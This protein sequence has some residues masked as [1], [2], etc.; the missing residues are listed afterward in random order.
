MALEENRAVLGVT[1]TRE[2]DWSGTT[3]YADARMT[4]S[5]VGN[6]TA[7]TGGTTS[8]DMSA[9]ELAA[10]KREVEQWVARDIRGQEARDESIAGAQLFQTGGPARTMPRGFGSGGFEMIR[11]GNWD[12]AL[13]VAADPFGL[14]GEL[15]GLKGDLA[16]LG[17][18]EAKN[19]IDDMRL[20]MMDA[21]VK[22]VPDYTRY[23]SGN[24]SGID[25]QATA[26][27]LGKTYE[28]HIRD[29]RMRETWGDDYQ[30]LRIGKSGMTPLAFE[31]KVLDIHQRAT[32]VA[33]ERGVELI[34]QGKLAVADGQYARTLGSFID[35]Q[36]RDQ[37]RVLAKMEG[38]NDSSLSNVWAINRRIKSDGVE[39]YGIPDGR[40]GHN[41]YHDTTLARKDGYTPQISKWN[42][43]REGNFLIVRPTPLGG[44]YVIP[45]DAIQPYAPHPRLPG[46][47]L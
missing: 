21:G 9:E 32:D 13:N 18:I 36:V 33:Y 7:D 35:T 5:D 10:R 4:V 30:N 28:N 25:F 23:I 8:D 31:Q 26:E 27:N 6:M 40:I 47:R 3:K 43:I 1:N 22:D 12:N 37:L 17:Q 24:G 14:L 34:A 20:R 2:P 45:R 39:G 11:N 15:P 29:Q 16:Q 46:R 41:T 38:I 42:A 19:R 44:S